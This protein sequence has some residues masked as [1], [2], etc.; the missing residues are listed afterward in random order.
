MWHFVGTGIARGGNAVSRQGPG[1]GTGRGQ[2]RGARVG[3]CAGARGRECRGSAAL[4]R[5]QRSELQ[6]GRRPTARAGSGA[7]HRGR[8]Q[9]P[10]VGSAL[11]GAVSLLLGPR[12]PAP[13]RSHPPASCPCCGSR[14][15]P[16]R[17]GNTPTPSDLGRRALSKPKR[18]VASVRPRGTCVLQFFGTFISSPFSQ[19]C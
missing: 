19:K 12:L 4:Y 3:T 17:P 11:P 1:S 14:L 2:A 15:P 9:R 13:A 5:A 18:L 8:L 16:G 10:W 7:P 6:R